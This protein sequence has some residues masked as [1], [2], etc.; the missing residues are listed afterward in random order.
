MADLT[1]EQKAAEDK[2]A[3]INKRKTKLK[4]SV[5]GMDATAAKLA[6]YSVQARGGTLDD[7]QKTIEALETG[8]VNVTPEQ[9]TPYDMPYVNRPKV[10]ILK[11]NLQ[12]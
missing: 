12:Q 11:H 5:K 6:Q 7:L 4:N 2:A 10:R 9:D 8:G 3:D 1:P